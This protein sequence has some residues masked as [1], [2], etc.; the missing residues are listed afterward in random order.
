MPITSSAGFIENSSV[1][2]SVKN[3]TDTKQLLEQ[4]IRTT[5]EQVKFSRSDPSGVLTNKYFVRQD[6][7]M[8]LV[9]GLADAYKR[10][11]WLP[12]E[13]RQSI[14]VII[15]VQY[16]AVRDMATSDDNVYGASWLASL[17]STSHAQNQVS[18]AQ[19]VIYGIDPF[20]NEVPPP[21]RKDCQLALLLDAPLGEWCSWL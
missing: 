1:L 2:T 3:D 15:G 11:A 7:D 8:C 16:N 10:G 14:K 20:E 13:L 5:F 21:P 9:R 6:G 12:Q 17:S 4:A 19:V 18:A